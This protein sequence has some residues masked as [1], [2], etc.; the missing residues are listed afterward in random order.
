MAIL[1]TSH[2][3]KGE[4]EV[5]NQE[6][7]AGFPDFIIDNETRILKDLLGIA[8]YNAFI[9]GLGAAT[10]RWVD[11]KNG[12]EYDYNEITYKFEG[13]VDL[14]KPIVY[15]RWIH[16]TAQKF[17]SAGVVSPT[18]SNSKMESPGRMIGKYNAEYFCKLGDECHQENT[19]YGFL[20]ANRDTYPEWDSSQWCPRGRVNILGL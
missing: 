13:M 11:L 18:P 16:K 14:L 19:L 20:Y 15:S 10:Q 3:A 9:A 4:Y 6:E 8:C 2:F 7:K 5:P 1:T 17:T 12:G